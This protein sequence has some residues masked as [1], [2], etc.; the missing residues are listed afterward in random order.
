MPGPR[1][2]NEAVVLT[3]AQMPRTITRIV[4]GI[5]EKN[6]GD[7]KLT[8]VGIHTRAAGVIPSTPQP[9]VTVA[10]AALSAIEAS[11]RPRVQAHCLQDLHC[12]AEAA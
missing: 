2:A 3:A 12:A 4:E 7:A 8:T 1:P 11:R 5:L 10:S 9:I 6:P